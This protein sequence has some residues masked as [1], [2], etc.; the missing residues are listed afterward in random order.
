MLCGMLPAEVNWG[1]PITP[2][3]VEEIVFAERDA[4][5]ALAE[6]TAAG[7]DAEAIA[8]AIRKR[9]NALIEGRALAR[10]PLE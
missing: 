2:Q 5:A 8:E 7:R 10:V 3:I 9:S 6:D 1:D 4:C